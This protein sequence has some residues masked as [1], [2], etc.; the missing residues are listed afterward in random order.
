MNVAR[1]TALRTGRIYPPGDTP[2]THFCYRLSPPHSVAGRIIQQKIPVIP[3]VIEPAN[4][5]FVTQCLN[6]LRHGV[7]VLSLIWVL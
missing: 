5:R 3:S 2:G 6:Q 7:P 1:L 4:S